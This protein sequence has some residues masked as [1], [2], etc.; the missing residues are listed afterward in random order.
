VQ[1]TSD[2]LAFREFSGGFVAA[3]GHALGSSPL[4]VQ[5]PAGKTYRDLSTHKPVSETLS[6]M[7]IIAT[8]LLLVKDEVSGE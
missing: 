1:W 5:L 8:V 7:P 3:N 2:V 4:M 6:V